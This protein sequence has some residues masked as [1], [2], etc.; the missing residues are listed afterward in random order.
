M[1][2]EMYSSRSKDGLC[3]GGGRFVS[4]AASEIF[5]SPVR[6]DYRQLSLLF[7]FLFLICPCLSFYP[8]ASCYNPDIP[9]RTASQFIPE[10]SYPSRIR[11]STR[12]SRSPCTSAASHTGVLAP[13]ADALVRDMSGIE[14]VEVADD[15][16]DDEGRESGHAGAGAA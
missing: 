15:E 3:A 14:E 7:H 12:F 11:I 5:V 8:P 1:R 10:D 6:S 16:E 2:P 9:R 4:S 13:L